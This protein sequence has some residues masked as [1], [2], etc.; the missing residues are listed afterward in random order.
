MTAT[1]LPDLNDAIIDETT[2]AQLFADLEACT[3]IV[4]V[5]L[6]GGAEDYSTQGA[7]DLALT[8]ELLRARKVRAA[9]LRYHFE[10]SMWCDTI[11]ALPVGY[12]LVRLAQSQTTIP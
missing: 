8:S 11:V 7:I 5:Q 10:G 12:R 4:E 3:A 6:K 9:Q 1:P 2:L